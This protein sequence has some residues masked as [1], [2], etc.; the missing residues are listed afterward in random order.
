[1]DPDSYNELTHLSNK[2]KKMW[3]WTGSPFANHNNIPPHFNKKTLQTLNR[4][5]YYPENWELNNLPEKNLNFS[6]GG[7]HP[8]P[9]QIFSCSFSVIFWKLCKNTNFIMYLLKMSCQNWTRTGGWKD[10]WDFSLLTPFKIWI[11]GISYNLTIY[12]SHMRERKVGSLVEVL[13]LSPA[14]GLRPRVGKSL[15]PQ[16]REPTFLSLIWEA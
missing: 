6:M 12:A 3:K 4:A 5:S 9:E 8:K 7:P 2:K 16:M 13:G 11:E 14:L 1:M 10:A 15:E